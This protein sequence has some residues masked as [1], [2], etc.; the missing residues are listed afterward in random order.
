LCRLRRDIEEVQQQLGVGKLVVGSV[1]E[2]VAGLSVVLIHAAA[3]VHHLLDIVGPARNVTSGRSR[4][5]LPI[6]RRAIHLGAGSFRRP[7]IER[8]GR[9]PREGVCWGTLA[10]RV[11]DGRGRRRWV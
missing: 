5:G 10:N 8:V 3:A 9:V 4:M 7:L 11:R 2:P 1:T 6:L